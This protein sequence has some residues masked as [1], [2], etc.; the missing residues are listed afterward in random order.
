MKI[1]F[2]RLLTFKYTRIKNPIL[3]VSLNQTWT[4]A[5]SNL[6]PRSSRSILG[7][8]HWLIIS[9]FEWSSLSSKALIEYF[10]VRLVITVIV[11]IKSAEF[12]PPHVTLVISWVIWSP[13][14]Q[15]MKI[16]GMKVFH[17]MLYTGVLCAWIQIKSC[18]NLILQ[19]T[20]E[21]RAGVCLGKYIQGCCVL[22][23]GYVLRYFD[24]YW[25]VQR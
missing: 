2:F 22:L 24:E 8:E 9:L 21:L 15:V 18:N 23:T 19:F 20:E 7:V 4:T 10:L 5:L 3:P 16:F 11:V 14:A 17:W 13:E 6:C 1:H 12:C 25:V